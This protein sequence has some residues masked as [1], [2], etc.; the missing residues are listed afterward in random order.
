MVELSL[1]EVWF[2]WAYDITQAPSF[3]VET[4]GPAGIQKLSLGGPVKADNRG[5]VELV[6]HHRQ[7]VLKVATMCA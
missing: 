2:S 1:Y 4:E 7:G 5:K 3:G 6:P